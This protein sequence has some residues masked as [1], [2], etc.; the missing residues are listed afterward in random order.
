MLLH[1]S[2][3]IVHIHDVWLGRD[4]GLPVALVGGVSLDHSGSLLLMLRGRR[5]LGHLRVPVV[6]VHRGDLGVRL[7]MMLLM[8]MLVLR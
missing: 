7:P 8:M 4:L 5:G 1:M 6:V 2:V 3:S